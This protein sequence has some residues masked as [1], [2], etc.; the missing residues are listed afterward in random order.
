MIEETEMVYMDLERI[1]N[2]LYPDMDTN[3]LLRYIISDFVEFSELRK[4]RVY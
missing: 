3:T 4:E 1:R 2:E